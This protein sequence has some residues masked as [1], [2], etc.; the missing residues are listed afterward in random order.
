[1]IFS[2]SLSFAADSVK[3]DADVISFE[4]SS[5]IAAAEGD[6]RLSDG[7]FHATAP[8]LEYDNT[9]QQ[10]TAFSSPG[11]KVVIF[12]AGKRLEG[13]RLDYNLAT[14]RGRMISPNGKVDAFYV[15]G[16]EIDVMPSS[17]ARSGGGEASGADGTGTEEDLAAVW[18]EATL[19]TCR[20]AH[21]HYRLV[22]RKVTIFPGSKMVLHMTK[23]YLGSVMVFMSPLD[24]TVPLGEKHAAQQIFPRLAYDE[25]K[26]AGLGITGSFNWNNGDLQMDFIGW[27]EG[28]FEMD[29]IA[30]QHLTPDLSVYAGIRRAYNKDMDET[31]WRSR[32]GID[33]SRSGWTMSMGWTRRELRAIEKSAGLVSRYILERNPEFRISSPWFR[34]PAVNGRFRVFGTWGNYRDIRKGESANY[35]RMGL[36]VQITGTPGA[37]K[38]FT[39]FYNARY[40]HYLYSDD[41]YDAQQVLNARVGVLFSLG[42]FDFK[43]AYL[44]QWVWGRSPMRWDRYGERDELF[45]EVALN[46]P[47]KSPEYYWNVG[48]RA[49][50]NFKSDELAEMVYKVAYNHHCLLWEAVYR[51]DLRGKNDWIGLT[52]SIKNIPGE[53]GLLGADNSLSNPFSH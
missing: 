12:T 53:F 48:V 27:S 46:I 50:Y 16:K 14:R 52:L 9:S 7:E 8:Y 29:A 35:D 19:T 11:Q 44:R 28:I 43:T 36:G 37:R 45:Q 38:N 1:L 21:P 42:Q 41:I 23:A 13:D 10:V 30:R 15:K 39:P 25:Y 47:T 5:G 26:G 4:E 32:W 31:D 6:V 24:I 33:Y 22:A 49:A 3:L 34:D 51:N 17:A 20:E 18:R 2:A 40:T